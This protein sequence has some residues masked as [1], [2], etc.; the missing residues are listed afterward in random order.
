MVDTA[1]LSDMEI[2]FLLSSGITIDFAGNGSIVPS[3][4]LSFLSSLTLACSYSESNHMQL[5]Q[6][7]NG[8]FLNIS[9]MQLQ[10]F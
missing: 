10:T 9:A 1:H 8:I 6:C 7:Q 5:Q 4:V 3:C 2:P